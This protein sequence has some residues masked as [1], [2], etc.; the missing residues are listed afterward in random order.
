MPV[1]TP[2]SAQTFRQHPM[3]RSL[4]SIGETYV[5]KGDE[6]GGRTLFESQGLQ[7]SIEHRDG[8]VFHQETRRDPSGRIVA[9]NEAEVQ[10]V[11][12]SGRQG[13]SYLVEHDGFL[14]ESPL[15]WYS[16]KQRWDL[17]PGFQAF[18]YHFD[19]PIQPNCLFCHAN[20]VEAVPGPINQYRSPIFQGHAI[21]CERC[22][23]PGELHV[24]RPTLVDGKD[25]TIVNPADLS[26]ALRDDVC[27]QCHLAGDSRILRVG[28]RSEDYRPGLPF[29]RFWT[30][31][32][33][34]P[35]RAEDRFV[36]QFEQMHEQQLLSRQRGSAR[37]HFLPRSTPFPRARGEGRLLP[38]SCL[39]CHAQR[40]CSLPASER[41]ERSKDDDCT[42]CHMPKASGFDIPHAATTNHR[43]PRH[44]CGGNRFTAP[45]GKTGRDRRDLII[46]H[47][48]RMDD[49]ERALVERDRGVAVCRDGAAGARVALPLLEAAL[50]ARRM[51]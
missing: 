42:G 19:R 23:G 38:R 26:P 6:G 12:G 50:A 17:S 49:E 8:H 4:A 35:D 9:K 11:V 3:G 7:Y 34:P 27:A 5:M 25:M 48:E 41:L 29:P 15:T 33:Q 1:V 22:H 21:G 45:P 44:E 10:F 32:V 51:T 16:R 31:F 37:V 24:A 47:R 40:G 36:G 20:R 14:F 43:I 28:R 2:K 46:F 39:M 18:N 30:V 13:S